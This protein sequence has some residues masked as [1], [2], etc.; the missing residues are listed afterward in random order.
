VFGIGKATIAGIKPGVYVGVG[1]MPQADGSQRAIRVTVFAEVQRGLGDGFRPWDVR[2]NSTMTNGAVEQT[3]SSVD[4]QVMMV[5]Y[6]GGEQKIVVPPDAIILAY[7]VS[8]KAELKPGAHVAIGR[9][10]KKLDGSLEANRVNVGR[11]EVV[12]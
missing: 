1:A 7:A 5:K 2:P 3:V 9:A 8:D 11:G 12:P 6:K 10:V 4:G